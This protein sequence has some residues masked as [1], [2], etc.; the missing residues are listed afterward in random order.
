MK[1]PSA[2][3]TIT[4]I[5]AGAI[6]SAMSAPSPQNDPSDSNIMS[7]SNTSSGV[8]NYTGVDNTAAC[9]FTMLAADTSGSGCLL[10][11]DE[12][13]L[14]LACCATFVTLD[15]SSDLDMLGTL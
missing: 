3:R 8:E 15:E 7:C 11:P 2:V 9:C 6:T 1:F 5:M 10:M 12:V 4:F 13:G 14:F